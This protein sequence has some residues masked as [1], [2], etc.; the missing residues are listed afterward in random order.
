MFYIYQ[1]MANLD[2]PQDLRS[3]E[4]EEKEEGEVSEELPLPTAEQI[5]LRAKSLPFLI[6]SHGLKLSMTHDA[7]RDK[8]IAYIR[9]L[10][11]MCLF[12]NLPKSQGVGGLSLYQ[13]YLDDKEEEKEEAEE[14]RKE[15]AQVFIEI[16]RSSWLL[17][18]EDK[19]LIAMRTMLDLF[20]KEHI[21]IIVEKKQAEI[22]KQQDELEPLLEDRKIKE[23]EIAELERYIASLKKGPVKVK[24]VSIFEDDIKKKRD[25]IDGLRLSLKQ[26]D[27]EI[28]KVR[29][30]IKSREEH[31]KEFKNISRLSTMYDLKKLIRVI[32]E[33][34]KV[35]EDKA[36]VLKKAKSS[37]RELI[38][39][40]LELTPQVWN[41][42]REQEEQR[43]RPTF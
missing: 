17:D 19:F 15:L 40:V 30:D 6:C 43:S 24:A 16:V 23:Q 35:S 27:E 3:E 11:L 29:A 41:L 36:E 4:E 26:C 42:K 31:L 18:E 34:E 38:D 13:K 21:N 37:L 39:D 33:E 25:R 32:D 10:L 28:E 12:E 1:S 9:K 14:T 22:K 20:G 8:S 5:E 2:Q 7:E